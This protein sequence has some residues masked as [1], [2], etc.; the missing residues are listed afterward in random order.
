MCKSSASSVSAPGAKKSGAEV[1]KPRSSSFR[2][3]R[4][5]GEAVWE[6]WHTGCLRSAGARRRAELAAGEEHPAD[7]PVKHRCCSSRAQLEEGCS[8][9]RAGQ[10][11]PAPGRKLQVTIKVPQRRFGAC[12]RRT[13]QWRG[14]RGSGGRARRCVK[15]LTGGFAWRGETM[16]IK[17]CTSELNRGQVLCCSDWLCGGVEALLESEGPPLGPR[18]LARIASIQLG[19]PH[20]DVDKWWTNLM[21]W[22]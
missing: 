18:L 3:C 5:V 11:D 4:E 7:R 21:R 17:S 1:V 14:K 12:R 16:G 13:G 9:L 10:E 8:L 2:V 19:L 22:W 15:G 20:A 6:P